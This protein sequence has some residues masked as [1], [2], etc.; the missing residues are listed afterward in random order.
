MA[1]EAGE[2]IA[3]TILSVN[4]R[5]YRF[6]SIP[7]ENESPDGRHHRGTLAALVCLARNR[8]RLP[9]PPYAADFRPSV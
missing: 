9:P 1:V 5:K 8:R 4:E 6:S 2:T 3:L 7:P